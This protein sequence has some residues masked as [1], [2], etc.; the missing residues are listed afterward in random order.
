MTI[1]PKLLLCLQINEDL[2]VHTD[3]ETLKAAA[4][5]ADNER[6]ERF[7]HSAQYDIKQDDFI[8]QAR[9]NEVEELGLEA[10]E[11]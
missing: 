11:V 2:V 4:S 1:T 5:Q 10:Y 3:L 7:L 8:T 9:V 6:V